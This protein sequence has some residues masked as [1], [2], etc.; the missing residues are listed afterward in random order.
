MIYSII[1][2]HQFPTLTNN[3]Y[4]SFAKNNRS[5]T[6]TPPFSTLLSP[7]PPR[8]IPSNKIPK[9][10]RSKSIALREARN[11]STTV[12][13]VQKVRHKRV[14]VRACEKGSAADGMGLGLHLPLPGTQ[15]ARAGPWPDPMMPSCSDTHICTRKRSMSS[16]DPSLRTYHGL[17][18]TPA[19]SLHLD[20]FSSQELQRQR[21]PS[22]SQAAN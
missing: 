18:T 6:Q 7:T 9:H 14:P 10:P 19:G 1:K 11:D 15:I 21:G 4:P 20:H 8:I 5:S 22:P 3:T 12:S 16:Y 13:M 17:T 2:K